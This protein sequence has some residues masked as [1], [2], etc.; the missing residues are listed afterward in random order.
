M[1][2][3][4]VVNDEV[5]DTPAEDI[6][7]DTEE[8]TIDNEMNMTLQSEL[9]ADL[10]LEFEN[11][12]SFNPTALERKI[13]AA[14]REVVRVR[15]YPSS[16]SDERINKDLYMYYSNIRNIALYDYNVIGAE[17]QSSMNENG[18]NRSYVDRNKLFKGII[19]IARV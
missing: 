4:E 16:Y 6:V 8:E 11:E 7:E 10:S 9:F 2:E 5:I 12:P 18:I 15:N 13:L 14:I 1:D 17:W 3:N 19:P